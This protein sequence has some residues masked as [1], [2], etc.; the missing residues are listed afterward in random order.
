MQYRNSLIAAAA[1]LLPA[2]TLAQ[3]SCGPSPS[4]SVQPSI[5]SG[6]SMQVVASGLSDPRGIMLDGAG[7]LLVV[8]SGRGVVSA[9]TLA[10][11]NGCVSVS[12]S[13]DV[14]ANLSVSAI[15]SR[16]YSLLTTK[17]LNHGIEISNDGKTLYASSTEDVYSWTYDPSAL[18]VSD[19]QTLVSNMSGT[20]HTTRTLLLSQMVPGYLLVSR[21]STSNLDFEAAS[22]ESAHSEVRA[23]N[24]NNR[25]GT[26]SFGDA[27]LRLG[28]GLRNDVGVAE[29]PI[30]G[31]IYTVENS[32]DQMTRMGVDIHENNPA[33]EMNYLGYANGS[34]DPQEGSNFGYPWCFSA[35][36]VSE[37]P[38][39]GNISVGTQFAIDAS[40]DLNNENRTD[41]YCA[42]QTQA[43]LVFQ[44]HMA[45]L[46][47]KFNDSGREAW[48][49]FH[50]SWDRTDPVGYKMSLV[51]FN[52]DGTPVD[53]LTSMTAATDIFANQD[54]SVCPDNC[55]R[56]VGMAIDP[57]GRIYVSSD[58]SGEVY[59]V[60]RTTAAMPT[61]S[62]GGSPTSSASSSA[63]SNAAS[64][65]TPPY[66]YSYGQP[67]IGAAFVPLLA[68]LL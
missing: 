22:L 64:Y 10:D 39:N 35:W 15:T 16:W 59:L 12:S 25:T 63:T 38:M 56:P 11:N 27:G 23:F 14:T 3:S 26:Y 31:Q 13:M 17:Q 48:V 54:N 68:F 41:A 66:G 43:R 61:A 40:P 21:G 33:E 45:P 62:S 46:D 8:E 19:R 49:T 37:L 50:G 24:L 18:T 51:H 2:F 60:S 42:R 20:D 4:G 57:Q 32:A 65:L 58:A 28:W 6:Y 5:A 34:G 47:I 30:G 55:F 52:E 36:N 44:A 67:F 29:H 1:T 53:D 9:H 7:H